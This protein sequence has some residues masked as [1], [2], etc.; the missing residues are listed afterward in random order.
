MD[1]TTKVMKKDKCYACLTLEA[2][3]IE[4]GKTKYGVIGGCRNATEGCNDLCPELRQRFPTEMS[5]C[6]VCSNDKISILFQ[7]ISV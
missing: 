7:A 1:S 4:N 2:T 5:S 3:A 6:K